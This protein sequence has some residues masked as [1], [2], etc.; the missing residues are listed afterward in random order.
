MCFVG[1]WIGVGQY[2]NPSRVGRR[3]IRSNSPPNYL[4]HYG[5]LPERWKGD[6]TELSIEPMA[7]PPLAM[8]SKEDLD[9]AVVEIRKK[10][11]ID[12]NVVRQIVANLVAGKHVLL[13]GPIAAGKTHLATLVSKLV[14]KS[15]NN[16][17][18]SEVATATSE[19]TTQDVIGGIYPKLD[20]NGSVQYS[21]QKGWVTDTV[22]QNW[23]IVGGSLARVN[24]SR[25]GVDY[26]GVW[27]VIDEFNRANIDRAF[28]ELFT[29]L[30][31]KMLKYPTTRNDARADQVP[32]PKDYRIIATLN[33]FDK[34]F[35]FKLSDALK[36]RFAYIELLPPSREKA[37]E[38]KYYVVSR[39]LE[40]LPAV[41]ELAKK[42]VLDA[43]HRSIRRGESDAEFLKILD[44]A[45]DMFS[46]IRLTKNL[47][48]GILNSMFKLVF[49]DN[50]MGQSLESGLDDA[51]VSNVIPQLE[52]LPK[53]SLESIKAFCCGNIVDLL[54][55]KKREQADFVYYQ[56]EFEKLMRFLPRDGIDKKVERYGKGEIE[57]REWENYNPWV[58]KSQPPLPV[59]R[60][61]LEDLISES[62]AL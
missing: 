9:S 46:F 54:K 60:K 26:R 4:R 49:V 16:G 57:D 48:T 39:G 14:W 13:A 62:E 15:F 55:S 42:I 41:P 58:G 2:S 59:F 37:E 30:E 11:I 36:R 44:S 6:G 40:D 24:H 17:Y 51:F 18:Y 10:L 12:D 22:W 43:E 31:Y 20:Q 61:A 28:G 47:G 53:W 3:R 21:I 32:I 34:H 38:E 29:A 25:D 35:L 33:T 52:N 19:W 8:P 7:D 23:G 45:H 1:R 5:S 56:R 50:S 27:L